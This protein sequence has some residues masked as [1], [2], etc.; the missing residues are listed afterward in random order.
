MSAVPAIPGFLQL[1]LWVKSVKRK[2]RIHRYI[3]V[4][5]AE[6]IIQ[7]VLL[8]EIVKNIILSLC[9]VCKKR[10]GF[11]VAISQSEY[12]WC[13]TW[14]SGKGAPYCTLGGNNILETQQKECRLSSSTLSILLKLYLRHK[15]A[16]PDM[17]KGLIFYNT[18][19]TE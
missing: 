9:I 6:I 2:E 14:R 3:I 17:K 7:F 15:I 8:G 16:L 12:W 10:G 13:F 11:C 5:W 19:I 1:C 4:M 18:I